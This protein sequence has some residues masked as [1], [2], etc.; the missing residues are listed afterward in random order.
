MIIPI[1]DVLLNNVV[2][3]RRLGPVGF[4]FTLHIYYLQPGYRA[5]S[6]LYLQRYKFNTSLSSDHPVVT[7]HGYNNH[8]KA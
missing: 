7:T 2:G 4:H 3:T 5:T 1:N 8:L 6:A